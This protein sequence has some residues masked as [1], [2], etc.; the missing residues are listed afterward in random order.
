MQHSTRPCCRT[1]GATIATLAS[2]HVGPEDLAADVRV[3]ADQLG[4]LELLEARN[5]RVGGTRREAEPEL[6]VLL[7]GHHV[8]VRVRL[9]PWGHP[10]EE[11]HASTSGR[12]VDLEEPAEPLDL[13]EG[14]DYY[15]PDAGFEC[16][17]Q[18]G[19]RLVV[20]VHDEPVR[21][22]SCSENDR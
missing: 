21:W 1:K 7:P 2:K 11:F 4:V 20:P 8:L 3:R 19:T 16:G 9:D 22:H 10:D 18:L 5:G 12:A 17:K 14:V 15:P 6:R 13:V